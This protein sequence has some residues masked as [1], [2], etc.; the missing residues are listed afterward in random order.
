MAPP[1]DPDDRDARWAARVLAELGRVLARDGVRLARRLERH[2]LPDDPREAL[3]A[4]AARRLLPLEPAVER[5]LPRAHLSLVAQ[6]FRELPP[7]DRRALWSRGR[8]RAAGAWAGGAREREHLAAALARL[9]RKAQALRRETGTAPG[10][11]H[12][13]LEEPRPPES[14]PEASG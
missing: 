5:P 14:R 8:P 13:F 11:H 4:L 2:H 7:A 10:D 12:Q 6:A 9:T 3:L 1:P